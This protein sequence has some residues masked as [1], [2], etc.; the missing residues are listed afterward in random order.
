V[1]RRL[2]TVEEAAARIGSPA[3][4]PGERAVVWGRIQSTYG[5]SSGRRPRAVVW[6]LGAA[7]AC[8]AIALAVAL[9]MGRKPAEP[10]AALAT[11]TCRLD[12]LET[13][14][15]LPA[16]CEARPVRVGDDEWVLTPGTRVSRI[17]AGARV[18]A[19]RVEFRVRPRSRAD[20][21]VHVAAGHQVR[22]IGTVFTIAQEGASGSVSVTEGTIE[23]TWNDGSRERV[24]AGQTLFWPRRAAVKEPPPADV[25]PPKSKPVASVPS[26]A[27]SAASAANLENVMDRV[28]QLKSQRRYGELIALL[29]RT[30]G[31]PEVGPV[32]RQRLSYELGLALEG[33][34]RGAC[35]HWKRHAR[36]YGAGRPGDALSGKL[37]RCKP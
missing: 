4:T 25:P 32:Q 12:P 22:V 11:T 6:G 33:A 20:F 10:P 3:L 15:E 18:E 9:T 21:R 26:A 13:T 36:S 37:E 7:A 28:L 8:A 17:E 29:Q 35:D 23:F 34:G 24:A 5:G 27:R 19:G 14:L 2:E 16:S 31:S 1:K 30:L